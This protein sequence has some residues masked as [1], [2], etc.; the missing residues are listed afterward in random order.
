MI[1]CSSCGATGVRIDLDVKATPPAHV[2]LKC[3]RKPTCL[4]CGHRRNRLI[5]QVGGAMADAICGPCVRAADAAELRRNTVTCTVA[6]C[7]ARV[8]IVETNDHGECAVCSTDR[9]Y[10]ENPIHQR[11]A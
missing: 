1:A 8:L 10:R 5:V 2:C 9:L 4:R 3:L 6:A 11:S 7:S